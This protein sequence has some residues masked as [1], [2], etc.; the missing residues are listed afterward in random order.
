[1]DFITVPLD[2]KFLKNEFHCGKPMLDAYLHRQASQDMKRKLCVVFV[3]PS[4][5]H[6]VKAYYTLSNSSIP[7]DQLPEDLIKRMPPSYTQLPATLI[8]RL[9]VDVHFKGQGLGQAILMDSLKRCLEAS[10]SSIG[11]V[12]VLVDPLDEEARNFY[13]HFFFVQLPGSEKMFL[14]MKTIETLF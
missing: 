14:T 9:A 11:S 12:V 8:G 1:M 13:R 10:K 5:T 4:E 3:H 7:K 6:E 2:S